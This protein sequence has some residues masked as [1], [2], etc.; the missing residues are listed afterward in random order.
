MSSGN[1]IYPFRIEGSEDFGT[2]PTH[3]ARGTG[4]FRIKWSGAFSVGNSRSHL[5]FEDGEF[6]LKNATIDNGFFFADEDK[7]RLG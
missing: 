7:A 5:S 6:E 3:G 4:Y 1:S 2:N